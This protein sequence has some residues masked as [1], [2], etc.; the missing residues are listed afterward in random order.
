MMRALWMWGMTPPP[1]MV[2]LIKVSNSSSPLMAS[3]KCLGVILFTLR[4]LLALPANSRTS[5]VRYSRIAAAYTAEVAPTLLDELTLL[6]KNLWILPTGNYIQRKDVSNQFLRTHRCITKENKFRVTYLKSSFG[7][8]GLW[9]FLW[10]ALAELATFTT[11]STFSTFSWL[12]KFEINLWQKENFSRIHAASKKDFKS[13]SSLRN[14][15]VGLC[16]AWNQCFN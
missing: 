12:Y 14:L 7:W 16:Y 1:A 15:K 11:F 4:S 8:S 3:C 10:S 6:F 5:A 9:G 2:A 13:P